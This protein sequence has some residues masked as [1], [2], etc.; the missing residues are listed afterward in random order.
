M[1]NV[2]FEDT[3]H[4]QLITGLGKGKLNNDFQFVWNDS[5]NVICV[6]TCTIPTKNRTENTLKVITLILNCVKIVFIP[7][8]VFQYNNYKIQILLL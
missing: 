2:S 3:N 5:I 6:S 7:K 4:V 1:F 8:K